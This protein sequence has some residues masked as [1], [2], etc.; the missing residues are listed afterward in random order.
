MG[1]FL[2]GPLVQCENN[3]AAKPSSIIPVE[4]NGSPW[5]FPWTP[6]E[7]H[8]S[9]WSF[10]RNPVEFH[11]SPW[12]FGYPR[13]EIGCC[14]QVLGCC[15]HGPPVVFCCTQVFLAAPRLFLLRPWPPVVFLV[16]PKAF[17]RES[18]LWPSHVSAP[19]LTFCDLCQPV[20]QGL[21]QQCRHRVYTLPPMPPSPIE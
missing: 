18:R 12:I 9:P 11:A 20:S 4:F 15:T 13:G 5:S 1:Y 3:K 19:M 16:A 14:T 8:V 2:Q 6:V 21:K 10:I 17:F 7:F